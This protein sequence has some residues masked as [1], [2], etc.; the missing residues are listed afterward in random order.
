MW[1]GGGDVLSP[2]LPTTRTGCQGRGG[3]GGGGAGGGR[4]RGRE[5]GGGLVGFWAPVPQR[6][7]VWS[8]GLW[9][10]KALCSAEPA[11]DCS[12]SVAGLPV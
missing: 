6:T 10:G 3:G 8:L 11:E 12:G 5:G 2:S 9:V 1:K 7:H 4:G